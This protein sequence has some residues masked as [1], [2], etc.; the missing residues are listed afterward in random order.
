MKAVC[1]Y[2]TGSFGVLG[3]TSSWTVQTDDGQYDTNAEVIVS[4]PPVG[5]TAVESF[6]SDIKDAAIAAVEALSG[7]T[8]SHSD[9]AVLGG[10]AL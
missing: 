1:R 9:I 7:P 6:I 10:P 2:E 5:S 8:M 4:V 3:Y